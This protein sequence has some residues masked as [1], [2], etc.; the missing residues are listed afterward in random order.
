MNSVSKAVKFVGLVLVLSFSVLLI[1]GCA[2]VSKGQQAMYVPEWM[3][4]PLTDRGDVISAIGIASPSIIPEAARGRAEADLYAK[5]T[6]RMGVY[7]TTRVKDLVEDHPVYEDAGL[8]HSHIFYQRI[9]DVISRSSLSTPF[10][11]EGWVDR[12]GRF[13]EPGMTYV[14]GWIRKAEPMAMGLRKVADALRARR[15]RMKLSR[16]TG[17][18]LDLL[19]EEMY[20]KADELEKQASEERKSEMKEVEKQAEELLEGM[21]D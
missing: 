11:S 16:E 17:K 20:E 15:M 6:K 2:T 18:E 12:V 4:K 9:T 19:I 14:Y 10:V 1:S 8:S 7:V 13:G 3:K 5:I 21:S